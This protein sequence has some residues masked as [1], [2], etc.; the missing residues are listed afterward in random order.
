MAGFVRDYV[1]NYRELKKGAEPTFDEYK[2]AMGSFSPLMLPVFSTIA[3][4]FAVYDSW[5]CAV[6]S[7]TFC[8]RSFFHASTSH[9][10]VTNKDHGGYDKWIDAPATPTIFNRLEEAGLTW[11]VYYDVQQLVSFTGVLHASV[12]QPYWKTNFRSME[13]FH[14]DV[15][16]GNLPGVLVHRAADD[17]QPQ[18]HASAVRHAA[19]RRVRGEQGLQQRVLRRARR[20]GAAALASTRRCATPAATR[21]RTR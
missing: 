19:R 17:L 3:K 21:A 15:K 2:V 14:E 9:G 20:R 7:Q 16:N 11:R 18:R 12:L 8:N 4:N 10:F 5:F 6:P 13:Q 1:I